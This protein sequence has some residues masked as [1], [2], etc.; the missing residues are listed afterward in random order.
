M[1]T[2][3]PKVPIEAY[4]NW[5][6]TPG[7]LRALR[8][9]IARLEVHMTYTFVDIFGDHW[10]YQHSVSTNARSVVTGIVDTLKCHTGP[11]ERAA[12]GELALKPK[13]K[14]EKRA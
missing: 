6:L 7:K 5:T 1:G 13:R 12:Q 14:R 8:A 4:N 9:G 11:N 2:V 10:K 3:G